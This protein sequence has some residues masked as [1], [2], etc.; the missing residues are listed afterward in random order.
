VTSQGRRSG[1][2]SWWLNRPAGWGRW[3]GQRVAGPGGASYRSSSASVLPCWSLAPWYW[4]ST[5]GR[6]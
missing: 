2:M 6:G 1:W 3:E 5:G 4:S